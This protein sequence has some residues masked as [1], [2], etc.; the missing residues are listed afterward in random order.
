MKKLIIILAI[1][2]LLPVSPYAG[3]PVVVVDGDGNTKVNYVHRDRDGATYII[4]DDNRLYVGDSDRDRTYLID[5]EGDLQLQ[6]GGDG[7]IVL[8]RD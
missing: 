5:D 1:A 8:P 3:E 6:L 2:L 7:V 4:T